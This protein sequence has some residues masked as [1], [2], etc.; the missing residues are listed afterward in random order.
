[1]AAEK[2]STEPEEGSVAYSL[3]VA[4]DVGDPEEAME[5]LLDITER[6]FDDAEVPYGRASRRGDQYS[7][8]ESAIY[9][10]IHW[11]DMPWEA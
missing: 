5:E 11:Y 7:V 1:M 6:L 4:P 8:A 2:Y 3:I 9:E 10:F